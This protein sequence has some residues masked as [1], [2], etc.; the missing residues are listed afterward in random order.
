MQ[1]GGQLGKRGTDARDLTQRV[2]ARREGEPFK[3]HNIQ[4][5]SLQH[6]QQQVVAQQQAQR[7]LQAQHA[8]R[9][10]HARAQQ[11][12]DSGAVSPQD[13]IRGPAPRREPSERDRERDEPLGGG[14]SGALGG[15]PLGGSREGQRREDRDGR[16][17]MPMQV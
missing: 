6:A 9:Q 2:D 12:R 8:Q 13:L 17:V 4:T 15:K 7:A 1:A 10:L 5:H 16:G 3:R 11:L 14:A